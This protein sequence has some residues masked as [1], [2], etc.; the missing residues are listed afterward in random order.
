MTYYY[1][2][3]EASRTYNTEPTLTDQA[4]ARDTDIN[5]I[6]GRFRRTGMVP[7]SQTQ[8]MSGDFTALPQDLRGYIEAAKQKE[9]IRRKLPKELQEMPIEELLALTPEQLRQKLTPP[10]PKT[11]E[12]ESK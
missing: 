10:E 11:P 5:V 9:L 4:G 8:P 7:V 6:I 3:K 1:R 2:N 12:G